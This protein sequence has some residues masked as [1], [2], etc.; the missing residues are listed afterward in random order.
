MKPSEHKKTVYFKKLTSEIR[1]KNESDKRIMD[2]VFKALFHDADKNALN[3][4]TEI[5]RPHKV[6]VPGPEA[7]RVWTVLVNPG[8]VSPV[9]GFGNAG[10]LALTKVGLAMMQQFGGY[11]DYLEAASHAQTPTETIIMPIDPGG[12]LPDIQLPETDASPR[13]SRRRIKR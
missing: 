12:T 10:K 7:S 3:F 8:W 2:L 11:I 9:I 4:E 13:K 6:K 5:L 1:K